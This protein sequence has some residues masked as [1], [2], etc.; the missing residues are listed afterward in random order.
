MCFQ[1]QNITT[2]LDGNVSYAWQ[3]VFFYLVPKTDQHLTICIC[4]YVFRLSCNPEREG[5]TTAATA[6]AAGAA[7]AEV[8]CARGAPGNPGRARALA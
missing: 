6:Y 7:A 8:G 4:E 5:Y 2:W 3:R 1:L